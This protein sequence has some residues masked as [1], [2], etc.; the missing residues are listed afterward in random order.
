MLTLYYKPTCAFSKAVLAE[1][2]RMN[3]K[4]NLKDVSYDVVLLQELLDRGGKEQTP[5]MV[6]QERGVTLYESGAIINYLHDH[7]AELIPKESFGGL[8]I[9]K[10]EEACD[11]C[12]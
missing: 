1:A 3:I 5:L 10:S 9:H 7:Q 4:M 11:S 2:E 12:Q 8:R 6:D